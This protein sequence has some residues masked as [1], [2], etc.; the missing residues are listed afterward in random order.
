MRQFRKFLNPV[1]AVFFLLAAGA[2][3]A[4]TTKKVV[5][6]KTTTTTT[7]TTTRRA[8]ARS[9]ASPVAAARTTSYH[10][11]PPGGPL[12]GPTLGGPT[13]LFFAD[14]AQVSPPHS[15]YWGAGFLY[16]SF[17]HVDQMT[18]P[19]FVNHGVAENL[20]LSASLPFISE[21]FD[22]P[23]GLDLKKDESGLG[24]LTFGGKY[25]IP[26]LPSDMP[27]FAIGADLGF[28]P[29]S[30][31]LG[32]NGV[33]IHVKGAATY[34]LPQGLL[35]NGGLGILHTGSRDVKVAGITVTTDGDTSV[36]LNGGLEYPLTPELSGIAELDINQFGKNDGVL[37][38]GVRG[39]AALRFQALIGLGIGSNAP[40]FTLGGNIG[41]PFGA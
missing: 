4:A 2:G 24:N 35:V 30:S 19:F 31:D 12:Q 29:L 36:Q 5:K 14:T 38:V 17:D 20:E 11:A 7:T 40:D 1:F 25:K 37:A 6:K 27:D 39:G 32:G 21:H 13:G 23:D 8:P 10:R 16:G 18:I 26:N 15:G 9:T 22:V 41:I 33:D 34:M 28:G 3:Q